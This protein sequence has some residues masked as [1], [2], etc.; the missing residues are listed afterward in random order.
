MD[1]RDFKI[2]KILNILMNPYIYL[3]SFNFKSE[4]FTFK[5]KFGIEITNFLYHARSYNVSQKSSRRSLS[6][7]SRIS[8]LHITALHNAEQ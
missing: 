4:I 5:I 8:A 6:N 7:K 3:H 2:Q 1:V